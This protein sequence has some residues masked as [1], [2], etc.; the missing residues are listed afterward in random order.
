MQI[1]KFAPY[2][3][4]YISFF[5]LE[6]QALNLFQNESCILELQVLSQPYKKLSYKQINQVHYPHI[7]IIQESMGEGEK[8]I[9]LL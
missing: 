5:T 9:Q 8:G 1:L 6:L 7:V 3:Y 4:I 2:I